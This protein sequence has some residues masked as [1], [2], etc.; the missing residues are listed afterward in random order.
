[1][2]D[3]GH[4]K[5]SGEQPIIVK[6]IKKGGHGHHG[7]AWKVAYA[8]F[9]TAMMAFFIVMWI[10]AQS[11]SVKTLVSSYFENPGAFEFV[12]GKDAVP[13]DLGLRP[14]QS[15]APGDADGTGQ[16]DLMKE[17][18]QFMTPEQVDSLYKSIIKEAQ[19]DSVELAK[20]LESTGDQ[21]KEEIKKMISENKEINDA[22]NSIQFTVSEEGLAIDLIES[23]EN[24]FF[25]V[26]SSELEPKVYVIL[27][28]LALALGQLPNHIEVEGHTDARNFSNKY[29]YT[30]W[31]LSADRAN[32]ARR[33][34]EMRGL[35][36]GQIQKVSGYADK[37]LLNKENP[38]DDKNR[39]VTV[40][41]RN[42]A[43]SEIV[44]E[45]TIEVLKEKVSEHSQGANNHKEE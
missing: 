4:G 31:E 9:V 33:S 11:E 29:G 5:K 44:K 23:K 34:F 17:L 35:W 37:K 30:N 15:T 25:K 43:T 19:K 10:L 6:K 27:E 45:K 41:I 42:I 24:L 40:V 36:E 26:G 14:K 8:D 32:S 20:N 28:K 38:F 2:S 16:S 13:I 3:D 22:L 12:T 21:L 39:R 1:M 7:G 18:G